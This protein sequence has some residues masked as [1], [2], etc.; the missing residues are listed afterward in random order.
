MDWCLRMTL[1]PFSLSHFSIMGTVRTWSYM[2][3]LLHKRS[4][5]STMCFSTI[6]NDPVIQFWSSLF[7]LSKIVEFGEWRGFVSLVPSQLHPSS[8]LPHPSSGESLS[9]PRVLTPLTHTPLQIP[10]NKDPS[11]HPENS[12]CVPTFSAEGSPNNGWYASYNSPSPRRHGLH[13]PA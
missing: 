12:P 8:G 11:P 4:L 5:M 7:V 2:G 1:H 13:H 9:H 3:M 6:S 10:C